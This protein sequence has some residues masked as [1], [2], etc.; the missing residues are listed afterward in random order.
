LLAG[1][2]ET[3]RN[4]LHL[5]TADDVF[6][7][8]VQLGVTAFTHQNTKT[9]EK[10]KMEPKPLVDAYLFDYGKNSR[11]YIAFYRH[12]KTLNWTIKSIKR[13]DESKSFDAPL[14]SKPFKDLAALLAK[15]NEN[16]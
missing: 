6:E 12:S 8:I 7:Y 1:A 14:T 5:E 9:L 16:K 10:G 13:N 3:A 2:E 15:T 11:G 4:E